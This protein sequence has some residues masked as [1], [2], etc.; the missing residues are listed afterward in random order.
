VTNCRVSRV[1]IVVFAVGFGNGG[2]GLDCRHIFG[3]LG[4]LVDVRGGVNAREV[5]VFWPGSFG[6]GGWLQGEVT[7]VRRKVGVCQGTRSEWQSRLALVPA[8]HSDL[9]MDSCDTPKGRHECEGR[10]ALAWCQAGSNI[11]NYMVL[12]L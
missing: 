3:E 11:A 10:L 4:G 6:H 1:V 9:G 5:V 2:G 12:S 7:L 8:R